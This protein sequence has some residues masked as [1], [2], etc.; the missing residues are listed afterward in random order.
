MARSEDKGG[1]N[2]ADESRSRGAGGFAVLVLVVLAVAAVLLML[3][4]RV[5]GPAD[6]ESS[7]RL[8]PPRPAI[9]D[10]PRLPSNPLPTPR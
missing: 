7:F 10:A 9:P 4:L 1:L 8:A 5:R 2:L 3:V 6:R